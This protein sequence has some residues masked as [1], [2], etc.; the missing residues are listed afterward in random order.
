M[1]IQIPYTVVTTFIFSTS[2]VSCH[3]L[4]DNNILFGHESDEDT[5]STKTAGGLNRR[6]MV[7][8]L[9]AE[10]KARNLDYYF[11]GHEHEH[12]A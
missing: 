3:G 4:E 2:I 6:H 8:L 12:E 7:N 1:K 10:E 11:P 5:T 9:E